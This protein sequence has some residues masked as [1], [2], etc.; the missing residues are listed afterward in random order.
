MKEKK[1]FRKVVVYQGRGCNSSDYTGLLM[2]TTVIAWLANVL[3]LLQKVPELEGSFFPIGF[4]LINLVLSFVLP[5][6]I[7]IPKR[8]VV[9]EEI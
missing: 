2:V 7:F 8:K 9:Y 4:L 3:Y 5:L 6:V 1:K